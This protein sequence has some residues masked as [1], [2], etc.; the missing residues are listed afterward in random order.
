MEKV[1][2]ELRYR[3]GYDIIKRAIVMGNEDLADINPHDEVH[4]I[5]PVGT[6]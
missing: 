6:L 3:F 2:E 4:Q 5:H 1:I